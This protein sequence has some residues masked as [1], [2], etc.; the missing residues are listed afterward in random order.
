[1]HRQ[2]LQLVDDCGAD[3]ALTLTFLTSEQQAWPEYLGSVG[4]IAETQDTFVFMVC[5]LKS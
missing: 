4:L 5:P 3:V 2:V 1:M